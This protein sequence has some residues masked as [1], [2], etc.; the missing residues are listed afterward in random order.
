[1]YLELINDL[2][3]NSYIFYL[4]FGMILVAVGVSQL[5]NLNHSFFQTQS[6]FSVDRQQQID[7][8]NYQVVVPSILH[9]TFISWFNKSCK[10][11][12]K[13]DDDQEEPSH[14]Y[15]YQIFNIRGG[16]IWNL[17]A[18]SQPLKNIR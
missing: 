1:M 6:F 10:I 7:V 13:L 3:I 8:D 11:I 4:Y 14:S 2:F 5:I 17:V 18:Y 16:R 12:D 15:V 9:E